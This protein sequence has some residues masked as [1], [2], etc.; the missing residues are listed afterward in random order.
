MLTSATSASDTLD[1]F[2]N[3]NGNYLIQVS[4]SS[5]QVLALLAHYSPEYPCMAEDSPSS[6]RAWNRLSAV[7][8]PAC[9]SPWKW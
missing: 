2:L 7:A 9:T 5:A 3:A 4:A 6:S 8:S 1:S